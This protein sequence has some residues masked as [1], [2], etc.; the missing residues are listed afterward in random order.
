MVHHARKSLK[1]AG[2]LGDKEQ[3]FRGQGWKSD[4]S[5]VLKDVIVNIQPLNK[6]QMFKLK[7]KLQS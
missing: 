2:E 5:D 1:I 6:A 7:L 4:L 3:T